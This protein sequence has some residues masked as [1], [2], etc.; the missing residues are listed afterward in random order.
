MI[1]SVENVYWAETAWVFS[2]VI[3]TA[4]TSKEILKSPQKHKCICQTIF[5]EN[6]TTQP[7]SQPQNCFII[8]DKENVMIINFIYTFYNESYSLFCF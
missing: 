5:K 2:D 1:C 4:L 7:D 6:E 3:R 8:A